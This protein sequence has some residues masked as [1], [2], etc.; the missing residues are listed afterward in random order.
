[1]PDQQHAANIIPIYKKYAAQWD[2][3]RRQHFYEQAWLDRF[4]RLI[5]PQSHILDLGCGA[6]LPI[7]P[8]LLE[9]G[10]RITGIDS[11]PA[12]LDLAGSRFPEQTWLLADMRELEL[13]QTFNAILA[14]DSFFHLT[15]TDQKTMFQIFARHAGTGTAL[16]FTS[17]PCHGIALGEMQ[18][19]VLYHASL[20]LEEY[21]FLLNQQGFKVIDRK[22]ED[23]DCTGHTVWLAQMA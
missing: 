7:A 19:E 10:H 22:I 12:M 21:E 4:L 8:Y 13:R 1:M 3:M 18:G 15:H 6:A 9:R 17:G 16:M 23:P 20:D 5:P 14:W 2:A 11:S